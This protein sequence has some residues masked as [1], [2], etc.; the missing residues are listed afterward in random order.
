MTVSSAPLK[1]ALDG[2]FQQ[3]H[4]AL[5]LALRRCLATGLKAV[6]TYLENGT[7]KMSTRPSSLQDIAR[8]QKEWKDLADAKPAIRSQFDACDEQRKLLV[9]VASGTVDVSD[10]MARFGRLPNAWENFE[11]ALGAFSAIVEEQRESLKG[12][13]ASEVKDVQV[14]NVQRLGAAHARAESLVCL[15]RDAS[16]SWPLAGMR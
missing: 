7:E 1:G 2:H 14:S 6:E 5:V 4:D 11:A 13:V 8:S 16:T 3:A 12:N 9:G 15:L 10:L